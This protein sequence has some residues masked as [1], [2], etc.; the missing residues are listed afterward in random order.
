MHEVQF[1]FLLAATLVGGK[2]LFLSVPAQ[3]TKDKTKET[4]AVAK[5]PTPSEITRTK[6]LKTKVSGSFQEMRLGD[7]LKDFADQVDAKGDQPVMWSYGKGFPFSQRV[8]YSCQDKPLDAVLD[9]LLTKAGKELGYVVVS[10]EG[11]KYDG[12]VRLTTTGERGQDSTAT[13]TATGD[14]EQSAGEKLALAKKLIAAGKLA[15]AKPV[16]GIIISNYPET[17][18]AGE[19]KEL[20][21]K[22]EK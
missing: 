16:L 20:L 13:A 15:S 5:N 4:A 6:L 3:V 17:K 18:A 14:L 1:L 2:E 7:I 9:Q 11:D 8:T 21:E 10:R 19:A 22:L 12:W